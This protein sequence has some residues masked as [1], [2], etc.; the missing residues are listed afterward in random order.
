ME[1]SIPRQPRVWVVGS[2][3][4][5]VTAL[6]ERHPRVGETVMGSEIHL[7]P[8]GKGTNQAVAARRAGAPTSLVARLGED[9]FADQIWAFLE[10]EGLDLTQTRRLAGSSTGTALVVVAEADNSIV[11]VPGAGGLLDVAGLEGAAIEAED[12]VVGQLESP[13][14]VTAAAFARARAA[15]ALTVLNPAPA[16][17]AARPL[18]ESADVIVLNETELAVFDAD[19][20][21][22]ADPAIALAGAARLRRHPGQSVVVTLGVAGAICASPA[23]PIR[24]EGR[25][26]EVADS[27]G[28]GDC[29]VGNL[30]AS[31]C[32]RKPI[33]EALELA[34]L[35]ASLSVQSIGAAVS[36]PDAPALQ[37]AAEKVRQEGESG[38][39]AG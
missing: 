27:T 30:A 35:A 34:N 32:A 5:D 2:I 9:V 23:G 33:A 10:A 11:V 28:A 16:L 20:P 39:A 25:V 15:G 21:T 1:K 29:F 22:P 19:P 8:G 26:V 17:P 6:A 37:A 12:V 18:L 13:L 36:M 14:D 3:H 24:V 4:M 38:V 31:L 7:S